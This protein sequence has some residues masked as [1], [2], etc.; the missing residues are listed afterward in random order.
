MLGPKQIMIW[1][2]HVYR[3]SD[4]TRW[5]AVAV[6]RH[7]EPRMV[8]RIQE[9]DGMFALGSGTDY[10]LV[11]FGGSAREDLGPVDQEKLKFAL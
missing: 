1:P 10:P 7:A 6:N 8:T 11:A 3:L 2:D 5:L 4:G 9:I